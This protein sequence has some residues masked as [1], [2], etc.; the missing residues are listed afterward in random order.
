[1]APWLRDATNN[2]FFEACSP[3]AK[4]S[5]DE[6]V[7]GLLYEMAR[8]VTACR[9]SVE[10]FDD[11]ARRF[12]VVTKMQRG[13][14]SVEARV[15]RDLKT[16]RELRSKLLE[17]LPTLTMVVP[18][19]SLGTD[20]DLLEP[21]PLRTLRRQS[22]LVAKGRDVATFSSDGTKRW[23]ESKVTI[24]SDWIEATLMKCHLIHATDLPHHAHTKQAIEKL[25]HDFLLHGANLTV[26]EPPPKPPRNNQPYY[27][28]N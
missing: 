3:C 5:D 13:P 16:F 11:V 12:V 20:K 18:L 14:R 28:R 7:L 2:F 19:S 4:K 22:T 26:I 10:R 27:K 25:L 24:L 23:F 15:F 21:L 9:A 17:L 1:M 6:E 8:S